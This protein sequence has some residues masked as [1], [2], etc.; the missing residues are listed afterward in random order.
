MT[1]KLGWCV[2][3]C[4]VRISQADL[5]ADSR[6]LLIFRISPI[7]AVFT[8]AT[9]ASRDHAAVAFLLINRIV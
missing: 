5:L 6:L 1:L 7:A 4:T 2:Q 9:A 8:L 3:V